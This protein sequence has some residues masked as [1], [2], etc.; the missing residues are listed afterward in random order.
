MLRG[1]WFCLSHSWQGLQVLT[2]LSRQGRG[3]SWCLQ[4]LTWAAQASAAC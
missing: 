1:L 4:H 2:V 3:L